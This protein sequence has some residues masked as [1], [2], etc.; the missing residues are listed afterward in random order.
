[1]L[2]E[3]IKGRSIKI[4]WEKFNTLNSQAVLL[5]FED[6][7]TDQIIPARFLQNSVS[8][9]GFG[10]EPLPR[11]GGY[12]EDGSPNPEFCIES[13]KGIKEKYG[14]Q[15][16]ISVAGSSREHASLGFGRL[17]ALKQWFQA[18]FADIFKKTM[19]SIMGT[20]ACF[21]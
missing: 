2:R 9:E 19:H 7:D 6:V 4:L 15:E 14:W 12:F 18:F 13:R 17:M 21:R 10:E 16:E 1:M 20:L 11:L 8:P 5:P 3:L